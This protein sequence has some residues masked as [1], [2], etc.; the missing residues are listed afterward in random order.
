[1]GTDSRAG[2]RGTGARGPGLKA[3]EHAGADEDEDEDGHLPG[4][5]RAAGRP[6]TDLA[7]HVQGKETRSGNPRRPRP[8][9]APG[10]HW[11]AARTP[12]EATPPGPARLGSLGGV[13][14]RPR[15]F[16]CRKGHA[17]KP[18]GREPTRPQEPRGWKMRPRPALLL[19]GVP[20][21]SG[22][23]MR[24]RPFYPM[25]REAAPPAAWETTPPEPRGWR[26]RPHPA[27]LLAR[28]PHAP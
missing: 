20:H 25:G 4:A 16:G 1:M 18:I 19:A 7:A 28:S 12:R 17:P 24:P 3:A 13:V 27:L 8:D 2:W 23:E 22:P 11:P 6:G 10:A 9:H 14:E 21:A 26:M 5:R 15:P